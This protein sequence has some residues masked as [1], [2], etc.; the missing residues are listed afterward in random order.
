MK[1]N[2]GKLTPSDCEMYDMNF[3][4]IS[5]WSTWN[6]SQRTNQTTGDLKIFIYGLFAISS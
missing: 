5:D 4:Q 1:D 2:R 3:T 6:I